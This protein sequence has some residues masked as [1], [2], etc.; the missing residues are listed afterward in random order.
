MMHSSATPRSAVPSVSLHLYSLTLVRPAPALP[1]PGP[2]APEVLN[3]PCADEVFHQVL[4]N[5]MSEE[6]LPQYDEKA[7]GA[8]FTLS[9]IDA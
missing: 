1:A 2:Q 4:Y 8:C 3:K 5:G 7:D 9:W 6:E